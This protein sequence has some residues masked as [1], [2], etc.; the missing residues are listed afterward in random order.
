MKILLIHL[1]AL[2]LVV[3]QRVRLRF[4]GLCYI[5]FSVCVCN[6]PLFVNVYIYGS[7]VTEEEVEY[8]IEL[9]IKHV[10]RLREMSP[11]WEMVQEG[12]D[13]KNID[14]GAGH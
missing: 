5:Q 11:L 4:C 8:A 6:K 1:F 3:L 13:I 2:V 12:V 9:C 10:T 7:C 14:W